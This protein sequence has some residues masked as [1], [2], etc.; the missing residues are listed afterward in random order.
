MRHTLWVKS[1]EWEHLGATC[2][3]DTGIGGW[4][5]E[6][7]GILVFFLVNVILGETR[8]IITGFPGE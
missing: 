5:R 1:I 6:G 2:Y 3:I 4:I 7:Q 8:K